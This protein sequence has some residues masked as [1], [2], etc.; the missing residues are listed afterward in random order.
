MADSVPHDALPS[1]RM[2][3]LTS[4]EI[5]D[6]VAQGCWTAVV[7][8]GATE[9]HG[10]HLPTFTDS[11]QAFAIGER[12]AERIGGLL[13]PPITVG[14]SDHHLAFPGTISLPDSVL[15]EILTAYCDGLVRAGFR[16][17]VVFSTHGGN[18]PLLKEAAPRLRD[19]FAPAEIVVL[20]DID[21][22]CTAYTRS[23][24]EQNLTVVRSPHADVA[25]T[26]ILLALTPDLVRM[27]R[28]EAGFVDE[29]PFD[30]LL[31]AGLASVTPNG[32]LGDPAGASAELGELCL[33]RTV[34][35]LESM[36]AFAL[37]NRP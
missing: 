32:V 25:E 17:I 7:V 4:P 37:D 10:P 28:A 30:Q 36:V 12:L 8:A 23:A 33:A 35:A 29:V 9:Q 31:R 34:D 18:F 27:D 2:W 21:A 24:A 20:C 5:E 22:Y 3:E 16:R 6:R 1:V 11:I 26:S 15:E 19:R 14:C 13:A